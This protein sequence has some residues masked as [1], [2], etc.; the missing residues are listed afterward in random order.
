MIIY[1]GDQGLHLPVCRFIEK[2]GITWRWLAY[3][4]VRAKQ[5]N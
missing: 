4:M 2:N 5:Y 1:M 3:R